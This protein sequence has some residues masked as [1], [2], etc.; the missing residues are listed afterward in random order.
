MILTLVKLKSQV[1]DV[2]LVDDTKETTTLILLS[3]KSIDKKSLS[4]IYLPQKNLFFKL[5]HIL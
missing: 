5:M 2:D 1:V 4:S 3:F